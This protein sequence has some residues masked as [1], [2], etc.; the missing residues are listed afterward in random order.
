M[1]NMK[2]QAARITIGKTKIGNNSA[3]EIRSLHW[4]PI[5]ERIDFKTSMLIYKYQNNQAPMYLQELIT[6][7]KIIHPWLHSS[8][9]KF[10]LEI[11]STKRCTFPN[12]SFSVYGPKL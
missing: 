1:Q 9:A 3:T 10:Q 7:K 4:L 12:R 6:E 5:K 2:N 11:T 8:K